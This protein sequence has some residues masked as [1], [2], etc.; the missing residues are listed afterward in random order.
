MSKKDK[1][2]FRKQLKAQIF[3]DMAKFE[4]ENKTSTTT[5]IQSKAQTASQLKV[6]PQSN[7]TVT[8]TTSSEIDLPQI[9]YDLKKTA[10]VV[11]GMVIII[12]TLAILDNKHNILNNFGNT[13]FK[14]LHIQ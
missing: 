12:A 14:A 2:K 3:Q 4:S 9:K 7:A 13:L 1:S 10:I 6:A 5:K 11:G 8:P